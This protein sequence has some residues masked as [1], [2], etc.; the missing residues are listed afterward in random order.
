MAGKHTGGPSLCPRAPTWRPSTQPWGPDTVIQTWWVVCWRMSQTSRPVARPNWQ[1]RVVD[2][3][4]PSSTPCSVSVRLWTANPPG[5]CALLA[6]GR[7]PT[8]SPCDRTTWAGVSS[9][10]LVCTIVC[11][12]RSWCKPQSLRTPS[13][14]PGTSAEAGSLSQHWWRPASPERWCATIFEMLT[15]VPVSSVSLTQPE[16]D[17]SVKRVTS[18]SLPARGRPCRTAGDAHQATSDSTHWGTVIRSVQVPVLWHH[19]VAAHHWTRRRR[20]L[21]HCTSEAM[22]TSTPSN[23]CRSRV[24]MF[25]LVIQCWWTDWTLRRIS[26]ATV[27]CRVLNCIPMNWKSWLGVRSDFS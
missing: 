15:T 22:N 6:D 11:L 17:A 24:V 25:G 3:P 27:N 10:A 7:E 14:P 1:T 26:G 18:V 23:L 19:A 2:A 5:C 21:P 9:S 4:W 16:M 12:P 13:E 8:W 20:S